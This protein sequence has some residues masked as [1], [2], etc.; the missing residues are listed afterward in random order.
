[1][2]TYLQVHEQYNLIQYVHI[3]FLKGEVNLNDKKI[4]EKFD[5]IRKEYIEARNELRKEYS[6]QFECLIEQLQDINNADKETSIQDY[7]DKIFD[8][9][10]TDLDE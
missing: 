7:I 6:N 9:M 2:C 1:M 8:F 4:I 3:I 5:E 10:C